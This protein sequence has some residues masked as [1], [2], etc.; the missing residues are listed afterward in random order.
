MDFTGESDYSG[1]SG[2][3][4]LCRF[5]R[6]GSNSCRFQIFV[7]NAIATVLVLKRVFACFLSPLNV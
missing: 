2:E 3:E 1:Y 7:V 4:K 6:F 5:D